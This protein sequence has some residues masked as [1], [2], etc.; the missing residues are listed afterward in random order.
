M[1][2]LLKLLRE[3]GLWA[4]FFGT[5]IEGDLTL[6]LAGVLAR[7]GVFT[8]GEALLV[9]TAGGFVGDSLSYLIGARFRNRARTLSIFLKARP[10]IEKLID[11]FGVSSAFI[12]KYVYGL[13]TASALF[14]GLA[15]FG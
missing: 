9:G 2:E 8:F 14:S 7:G 3:Y 6:L 10:R 15:Q 5:M 4:V 1:Q 12:V 11:R 13:R